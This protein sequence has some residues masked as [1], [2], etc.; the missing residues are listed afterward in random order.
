LVEVLTAFAVASVIIVASVALM[1]NMIASFDRGTSRASAGERLVLAADRLAADI[2][3]ARFVLQPATTGKGVAFLGEPTGITFVAAGLIDPARRSDQA[4]PAMSEIVN[5]TA[6]VVEETTELVRRRAP[7]GD[8]RM[9]IDQAV[10]RDEVVLLAGRFD[11]AFTFAR[12]TPDGAIT[13]SNTWIGEQ[14][15]PLLVKLSLRERATGIDLL[16]GAEFVIRADAP[17]ACAAAGIGAECLTSP[18]GQQQQAPSAN[19]IQRGRASQ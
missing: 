1:R 8:P 16:G 13:W 15:L 4:L 9:S 19:A 5:V 17:P 10:L 18:A 14:S 2:G 7:F 11:A 6:Q 3:S 12:Q